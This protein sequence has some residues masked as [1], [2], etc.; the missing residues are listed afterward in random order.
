[1]R[2]A[3]RPLSAGWVAGS[4]RAQTLLQRRLGGNGARR[5]A[6]ASSLEGAL[7]QLSAT[8]YGRTCR[9]GMSLTSAQ[10][11]VA[12][13]LL[14]H[15][16]VLAGWV[17]PQALEPL[18]AL[19]AW[20]EI[21]NVDD[22]LAYLGGAE[23][24]TPFALGGL[25]TAWPRLADAGSTAEIRA[26]LIGS[27]WGDPGDDDLDW[28]RLAM[29]LAWARR[30][31]A[32]LPDAEAWAAGAVAL[33]IARERFLAA[34]PL[35]VLT[36]LRPP[37]V[38]TAW[39]VAATVEQLRDSL[40]AEAAWALDGIGAPEAIWEGEVAWWRRVDDDAQRLVRSE[41]M[42][43]HTVI[44]SAVL[45]GVDAWRTSG[46]LESAARRGGPTAQGVVDAIL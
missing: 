42:G 41:P 24:D 25:A 37:A 23:V 17:P 26:R 13:T 21:A 8:A 29:R 34:R 43:A 27:G 2:A 10:R 18:R 9:P 33:L 16:R 35:D 32:C 28:I 5:L 20:F 31:L 36:R 4:V 39:P 3:L 12:D 19:A 45:L 7:E 38:G 15:L 30:V 1:M 40:P 44:G 14:W 46:A 6:G 11:A 22:R